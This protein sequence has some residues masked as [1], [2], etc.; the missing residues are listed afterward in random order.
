MNLYLPNYKDKARLA[1]VVK[2]EDETIEHEQ[3]VIGEKFAYFKSDNL[4][5]IGEDLTVLKYS[6]HQRLFLLAIKR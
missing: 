4:H 6:F 5:I 3:L 2:E 1:I